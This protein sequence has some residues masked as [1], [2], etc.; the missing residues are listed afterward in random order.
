[1]TRILSTFAAAAMAMGAATSFAQADPM[2]MMQGWA[3]C[4][5]TYAQCLRDGTDATIAATPAEGMAKMQAN[6]SNGAACNQALMACY[7]SA[8]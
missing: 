4:N 8:R 7:A 5:E 3:A 2:T 6:M 1:M